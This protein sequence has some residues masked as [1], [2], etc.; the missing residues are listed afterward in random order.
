M[1]GHP[2]PADDTPP[3][4][5][6][7]TRHIGGSYFWY[8]AAVGTFS[9]FAA[10]YYRSLGFS[11]FEVGIL[12]A[13]APL[14]MALLGPV[15]G[16]LADA[17][18]LHRPILRGALAL[19][20]ILAVAVAQVSSF[21]AVMALIGLLA[22]VATP[23]PSLLDAYAMTITERAKVAFGSLRVWGSLGFMVLTLGLPRLIGKEVTSG[24]LLAYGGCFALTLALSLGLPPLA[25]RAPRAILSGLG[26]TL[27][28]QSLL[29]LLVTAYLL[30]CSSAIMYVFLGIHIRELGGSTSLVGM[31]FA[32]SAFSELPIVAFGAW[33]LRR[34]GP[35]RLLG[36]ALVVYAVRYLAF[37][38]VTDPVWILPVQLLHGISYG[39]YLMASV[40]LAHRVGGRARAA[41]AQALLTAVSFGFGNI[42]GSLVG[43][44]LLDTVG[45]A[46][47]FRG[48]SVLVLVTLGVLAIGNR[49]IGLDREPAHD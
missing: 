37:S 16:A 43:G 33:F 30:A 11:G 9:P 46:G 25:E 8:Y 29:L 28:N 27:R 39:I 21:A 17:H 38:L 10:L 44:A 26:E 23:I 1:D 12:S 20:A 47:L 22:I 13:L 41:T 45:T 48:A 34:F 32:T 7:A 5:H 24:Y 31:A 4:W 6:R 15:F 14:S 19:A 18:G 36:I 49:T 35:T 3:A 42:T 2:L 40:T